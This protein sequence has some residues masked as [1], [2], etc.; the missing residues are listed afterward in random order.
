MKKII[1]ICLILMF[2]MLFPINANASTLNL[3]EGEQ[4][5]RV[6]QLPYYKKSPTSLVEITNLRKVIKKDNYVPVVFLNDI[7][8]KNINIDENIQFILPAGL[9]T[10]EGTMLLP[11][12]N[13]KLCP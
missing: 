13:E 8:T 6:E 3:V 4:A 7:S 9:S 11:Q 12:N 1:T 5:L 10:V 2:T